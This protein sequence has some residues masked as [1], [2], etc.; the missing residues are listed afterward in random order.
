MDS[1]TGFV[2]QNMKKII[3]IDAD[4]FYASV[5]TRENP[6]LKFL[7]IAVGGDPNK[8]GVIAMCNYE[9]RKFG[10]HSAM[11]SALAVKLCPALQILPP[12]M[13]LYKEYSLSMR[14]IFSHYTDK[15]EPL[16]LEP[17]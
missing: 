13:A 8:R 11:S 16:S 14:E 1:D 2:S 10:V 15:I 17:V 12:R 3:H 6:K 7:P 4:S 9:A 5:E